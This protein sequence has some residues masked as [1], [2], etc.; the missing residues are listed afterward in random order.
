L[1]L[2]E[3]LAWLLRL[4]FG[5]FERSVQHLLQFLHGFPSSVWGG[6][7]A[8][9]CA[10]CGQ[11]NMNPSTSQLLPEGHDFVPSIALSVGRRVA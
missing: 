6:G 5:D 8:D 3:G 4:T 11:W 10:V 9:V 1:A 2:I 7:A